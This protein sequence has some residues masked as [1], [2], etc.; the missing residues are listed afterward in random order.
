M[1][2]NMLAVVVLG[3]PSLFCSI[4]YADSATCSA[5]RKIERVA[6][7]P[8]DGTTSESLLAQAE[9][10]TRD[11]LKEFDQECDLISGKIEELSVIRKE[12]NDTTGGFHS[13]CRANGDVTIVH[14]CVCN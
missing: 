6:S 5:V 8:C 1:K 4:V 7:S 9:A 10:E 2:I 14:Q 11:R 12:Y 13:L 3:V